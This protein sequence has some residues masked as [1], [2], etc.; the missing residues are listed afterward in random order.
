MAQSPF[1][2]NLEYGP[3]A[4]AL[5]TWYNGLMTRPR[6]SQ[7]GKF[8]LAQHVLQQMDPKELTQAEVD[9]FR[10]KVLDS[11]WFKSRFGLYN[12]AYG[13][14]YGYDWKGIPKIARRRHVLL[15][16]VAHWLTSSDQAYHG[17]EFCEHYLALVQHFMGKD[18]ATI[19]KAE[20]KLRKVKFRPP[21]KMSDEAR[22]AAGD[23]LMAARAKRAGLEA[24]AMLESMD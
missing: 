9:A 13:G 17:R 8:Y 12:H 24:L 19:L 20:F 14:Q 15:R 18:E 1:Q 11:S 7:R 5:T 4:F 2:V 23:R 3:R 6:D 10:K 22:A 21:R 16:E